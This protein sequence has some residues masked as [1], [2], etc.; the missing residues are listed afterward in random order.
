MTQKLHL[1][2]PGNWINDPNGFIYYKGQYHLF[3]QYFPFEPRWG[4]MHWGHAVSDDLVTWEHKG[5]ALFPSKYP[6]QDGCFS[7]SSIE[8]DGKM[9]LFYTGVHYTEIDP[10]NIHACV[11]DRFESSQMM[12]TSDDGMKFDNL[13]DKKV[14]MY[15]IMDKKLGDATH[16]RDPKVWRGKDAWYMVLGTTSEERNGKLL[17][18][19]SHNLYTWTYANQVSREGYGWMWEC[20]DYFKVNDRDVLIFSPM[21]IMKD[22]GIEEN[23]AVCTLVDFDEETCHMEIPDTYQFIDYGFD[24]YAPQSTVDEEGRRV[25][26]AWLRMPQAVDGKWNGMFCFPRIVEVED[27]HIYFRV[28]PNVKNKFTKKIS[29]MQDIEEECYY[30]SMDMEEGDWLNVG[31][32][33]ITY[34]DHKIQTD[35]SEVFAGFED[36]C[37]QFASPEINGSAHLDIYVG[38]NIVE[39]YINDGEYVISNVVYGI[40]N[41]IIA[42]SRQDDVNI[43]VAE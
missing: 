21:G 8:H 7:G 26:I 2:A 5:V 19:K 38:K 20:P 16:T 18:F 35:R 10:D 1:K 31:G 24:L 42:S 9:F 22:E 39:V 33:Q 41:D 17:F 27:G 6:D 30:L 37:S 13:N 29:S 32:Y 15:P 43:Y 4:K 40:R 28:H 36:R 14:I 25:M 12:I 3:Y 23:Q 34:A 11:Q